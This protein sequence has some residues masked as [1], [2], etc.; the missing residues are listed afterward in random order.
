MCMQRCR[1][2]ITPGAIHSFWPRRYVSTVDMRADL[3]QG[4]KEIPQPS[5]PIV[6]AYTPV[7]KALWKER[8]KLRG[9]RAPTH[10]MPA[11]VSKAPQLTS[12]TYN[13]STDPELLEI[14]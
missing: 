11:P 3:E 6:G 13:F 4:G 5:T 2:S 8:L 9:M 10:G 1:S 7:T 12:V 14:V